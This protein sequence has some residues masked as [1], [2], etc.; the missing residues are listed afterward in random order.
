MWH[1]QSSWLW[2]IGGSLCLTDAKPLDGSSVADVMYKI[3]TPACIS[4][5]LTVGQITTD[6]A[7][8]IV[9]GESTSLFYTLRI[10][11]DVHLLKI[12]HNESVQYISASIACSKIQVSY[13]FVLFF[14][15]VGP[16]PVFF[17]K[18]MCFNIF[19]AGLFLLPTNNPMNDW[20]RRSQG[21]TGLRPR[22]KRG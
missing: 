16:R 7:L 4:M 9:R 19:T 1:C 17:L 11:V 12:K 14:Q 13:V 10:C 20:L 22:G 21:Q 3:T 5:S 2:I 6:T 18:T 15:G 8:L